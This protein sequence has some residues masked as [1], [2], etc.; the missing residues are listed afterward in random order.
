MAR[1]VTLFIPCFVDQFGPQIG[2]DMIRVLRRI[3][4]EVNFST[5]Q[6]CCG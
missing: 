2:L 4:W 5:E 6:T 1:R 3:G